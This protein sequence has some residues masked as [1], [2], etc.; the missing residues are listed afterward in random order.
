MIS[1]L[2]KTGVEMKVT[3]NEQPGEQTVKL[4]KAKIRHSVTLAPDVIES[5]KQKANVKQ[6][7]ND[8]LLSPKA[9][10][11]PLSVLGREPSSKQSQKGDSTSVKGAPSSNKIRQAVADILS[12]LSSANKSKKSKK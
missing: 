11:K 7:I 5:I 2:K 3:F 9:V 8:D 6:V 12:T 4:D 10:S 1:A